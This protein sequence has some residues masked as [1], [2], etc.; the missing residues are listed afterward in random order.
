MKLRLLF[1]LKIFTILIIVSSCA[2]TYDGEPATLVIKNAKV[3]TID[4][5]NPRAEAIA[6]L[7]DKI[8]AVTSNKKIKKYIKDDVTKVI[9]ILCS[10]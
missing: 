10:Q 8:L 6:F 7:D 3:V 1:L 5:E 2:Q 9:M 4:K